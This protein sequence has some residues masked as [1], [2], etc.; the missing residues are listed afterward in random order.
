MK[1]HECKFGYVVVDESNGKVEEF[2]VYPQYRGRGYA[3]TVSRLMPWKC[4][5][6]AVPLIQEGEGLGHR[7]LE[8]FY[9][10]LGFRRNGVIM[11]RG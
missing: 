8:A 6:I 11:E 2:V 1:R 3:R 5:L 10:R 9:E 7:E 4:W